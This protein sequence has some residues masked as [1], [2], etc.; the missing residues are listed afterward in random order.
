MARLPAML[1]LMV[2]TNM[3]MLMPTRLLMP[4]GL[5]KEVGMMLPWTSDP[6]LLPERG[7]SIR[8]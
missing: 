5:V 2:T 1:L 6:S 4:V 7:V 3:S 8:L